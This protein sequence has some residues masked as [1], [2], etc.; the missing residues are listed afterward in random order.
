MILRDTLT[1]DIFYVSFSFGKGDCDSM[2]I[3]KA[4][5]K[6]IL[7]FRENLGIFGNNAMRSEVTES[8]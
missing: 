8:S 4:H 1:L 3:L 6:E 2:D 5:N 7:I